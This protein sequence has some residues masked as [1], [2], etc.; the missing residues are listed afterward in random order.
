MDKRPRGLVSMFEGLAEVLLASVHF[1][2][3]S[4]EA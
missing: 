1:A 4:Y 2:A 3:S